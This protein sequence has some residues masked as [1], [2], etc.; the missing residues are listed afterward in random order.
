MYSFLCLLLLLFMPIHSAA[1]DSWYW[2]FWIFLGG[3]IYRI[4]LVCLLG[5]R[6]LDVFKLAI[7]NH[8]GGRGGKGKGKGRFFF[9]DLG[10]SISFFHLGF[11]LPCQLY[12]MK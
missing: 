2:I 7:D 5:C 10:I 8:W 3:L 12:N 11:G 1:S 4:L 6:A 9:F